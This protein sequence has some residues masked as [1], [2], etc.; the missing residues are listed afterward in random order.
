MGRA[1]TL[2]TVD[3]PV[4]MPGSDKPIGVTPDAVL[5]TSFRV[6]TEVKAFLKLTQKV[7]RSRG[8]HPSG[9]S[10]LCIMK[11]WIYETSINNFAH[12]DPAVIQE[13][14][15]TVRTILDTEH[16]AKPG[17]APTH[18]QA[19]FHGGDSIHEYQQF[20]FGERGYLWGRWKCPHC[21]VTTE[22]GFMPRMQGRDRNGKPMMV[23]AY[24]PACRGGNYAARYRQVKWKYV[25]PFVGLPEWDLGGNTDGILL[26]PYRNVVV[27]AI[28][29][30]KS[31]NEGGYYG[32][33][34]EPLPRAD[35]IAQASNYV[36]SARQTYPFLR[37]MRH[38]YFIYVNKNAQRDAKEF[39]VPVD[40]GVVQ[41]MTDTMR[42]SL[43]AKR[44]SGP[45][46]HARRCPAIESIDATKCPVVEKCW[47]RKPPANF[48][49]ENFSAEDLPL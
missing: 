20:R 43:E 42:V 45:P 17:R 35:H 46:V 19:D 1:K 2:P 38:I 33:Y 47:G 18:L 8:F 37:D 3:N 30:I 39:L 15:R 48:F 29:E 13:A 25:E 12:H 5:P 44:G 36:W 9:L 31:I 34:G 32:R 49:S 16:D 23:A 40:M 14:M 24:C 11:H 7:P 26:Y 6:N 41:K 4:T 22:P 27:P 21:R 28:F 10:R